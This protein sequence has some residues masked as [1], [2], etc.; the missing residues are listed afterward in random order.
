MK[1]IFV[2]SSDGYLARGETDDMTW[3]PTLD[4]KIYKLL[5]HAFG[6]TC[7]C[8]RLT[9]KLLPDKM[10]HDSN[11][12]FIIAE[13][14]G[15]NSLTNLSKIYPNGILI[16]GP[17]FLQTA[18]NLGIIDTFII[19]TVSININST[20]KYKNPFKNILTT[21]SCKIELPDMKICVYNN[22]NNKQR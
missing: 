15:T 19:T 21:P 9:Y 6:G 4:K 18:Y 5:T 10:L 20:Q 14:S 3:T 22:I 7:I 2:E 16:G 12:K 1:A 11:R 8:S 17:T 13:R